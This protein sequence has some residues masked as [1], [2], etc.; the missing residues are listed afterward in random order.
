MADK[1]REK[2]AFTNSYRGLYQF[3]VMPFG[4]MNAPGVFIQ[5]ISQVLQGCEQFSTAYIDD[6][7]CFS[8]TIEDHM[9]HLQIIFNRLRKHGLK[10]KLK[11]CTFL[12]PETSYLG[13]HVTRD[14][15]Q[16]ETDKVEAIRKVNPPT[17]KKQIRSFIG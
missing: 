12:Q 13:Y 5:L 4:L 16:P 10:L 9:K 3:K 15:I 11:K 7:L 14:G 6:I 1:D 17:S 8:E 2:T